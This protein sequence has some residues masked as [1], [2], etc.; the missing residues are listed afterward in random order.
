M[1]LNR[2]IKTHTCPYCEKPITDK[3]L[4]KEPNKF[5]TTKEVKTFC[6]YCH[7]QVEKTILKKYVALGLVLMLI[8]AQ[9]QAYLRT[10]PSLSEFWIV[11]V[12]ALLNFLV[13][14]PITMYGGINASY[15]RSK[16]L[17]DNII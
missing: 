6:P 17:F 7:G 2:F 5:F 14:F 15:V 13:A 12:G 10:L 1:N 9:I 16:T 8:I 4:I 3:T 11:V